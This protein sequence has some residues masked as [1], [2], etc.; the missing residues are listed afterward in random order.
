MG[1]KEGEHMFA[2][3]YVAIWGG[4]AI[5]ISHFF[6]CFGPSQRRNLSELT[7]L[8]LLNGPLKQRTHVILAVK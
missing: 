2:L 8:K 3:C 1:D 4:A 6:S 7:I 5:L